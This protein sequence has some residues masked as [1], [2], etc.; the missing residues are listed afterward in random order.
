MVVHIT[1]EGMQIPFENGNP[2]HKQ[3]E[4]PP[5]FLGSTPAEVITAVNAK[6]TINVND[7]LDLLK[8]VH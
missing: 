4:R 7:L 1:L 6:L 3:N 5:D 2:Q 8:R